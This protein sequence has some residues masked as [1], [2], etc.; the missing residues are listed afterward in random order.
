MPQ[1]ITMTPEFWTPQGEAEGRYR[2]FPVRVFGG[3]PGERGAVKVIAKGDHVA[4]GTWQG[5]ERQDPHRVE[6]R[7]DRYHLCGGCP[8]MH[9]DTAGQ[10]RARR[11]MVRQELVTAGLKDIVVGELIPCPDGDEG[12]RH[13]I[14]LGVGYSEQ[15]ALRVGAW[16]RRTRTV[17]PIPKCN[18]AA[19][20]LRFVM[21]TI[22][23]QV[24]ELEIKPYE[25]ERD[26]GVLR[27]IVLRASRTT[28]E[29]LVTI[30]AGNRIKALDEMAENIGA[31]AREVTGVVLHINDVPGNAIFY[32]D[33]AGGVP[34]QI[35]HG[36]PWIEDELDGVVYRIGPGDFFQ[37]NPATAG[38]LYKHTIEALGLTDGEPVVDLYCGV[39]GFALPAARATGWALGVEEVDGAV[40][41]AREA[42]KRNGLN[43]EFMAGKVEELLPQ[44]KARLPDARPVVIVN[45]ARRGLEP[46]VGKALLELKP[47]RIAY[48]SC[49][50]RAMARDLLEF[51]EAGYQV[52]P[53]AL[54]DMFP[55]TAHV[56]TAVILR[57][58]AAEGFVRRAP[59]RS[60]APK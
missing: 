9:L 44:V 3:I 22:A 25:V 23:H 49:N 16:G 33:E 41:A 27:A 24:R 18:V 31:A 11:E 32:R 7:C 26:T 2:D 4:Y 52:G 40:L 50:P 17:V 60:R 20:I 1:M 15:G 59:R 57:D 29:V 6:P 12:F 14:K 37:T 10:A 28:G 48:I 46:G 38:V 42:A 53:V 30:V 55:H 8:M 51:Q 47:R 34:V 21:G 45:P 13:I 19:P 39:G 43:A 56:E 58:P 35:L 5:S 36:K 54:F